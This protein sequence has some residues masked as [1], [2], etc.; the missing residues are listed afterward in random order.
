MDSII[1]YNDTKERC[2]D[3]HR[4]I[5]KNDVVMYKGISRI[6]VNDNATTKEAS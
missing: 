4:I 2:N 6:I 5:V 1:I 3:I